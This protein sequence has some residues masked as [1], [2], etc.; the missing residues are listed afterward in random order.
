LAADIA[1]ANTI[2][3]VVAYIE[4]LGAS[5]AYHVASQAGAIYAN[6]GALVGS[7]GTYAV[8][9]DLSAY[10]EKEGIKT[11]V[12]RAGEFKGMGEPGSRVSDA[13]LENLQGMV[14]RVNALF[15]ERVSAGR[16]LSAEQMK[17]IATGAV[18]ISNEAKTMGLVDGVKSFEDVIAELEASAQAPKN[19]KS[20]VKQ[21]IQEETETMSEENKVE[22]PKAASIAEIKAA[23][24]GAEAAWVLG[25]IEKGASLQ[26]AQTEFIKV[27]AAHNEL[28]RAESEAAQAA[29]NKPGN[30]PVGSGKASGNYE[31]TAK[32]EWDRLVG[33]AVKSG[34]NRTRALSHVN[35]KNP[36]LREAMLDEVNAR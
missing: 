31:G 33:E 11:H 21:T 17:G 34:M 10:Y 23:C 26:E 13:Q 3:P 35:A 8:V 30:A 22:T 20:G 9:R 24:P 12:I 16:K 18:W 15:L 14:E 25:Q 28:L 36:G 4:D 7:I 5:A 27:Q 2:K 19:K 1:K 6:E 32:S 29:L